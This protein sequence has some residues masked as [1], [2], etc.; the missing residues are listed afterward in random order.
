MRVSTNLS[1]KILWFMLQNSWIS[2]KCSR[3]FNSVCP[4]PFTKHCL[5]VNMYCA[6]RINSN[7][8]EKAI[9]VS[10]INKA[11]TPYLLAV[12]SWSRALFSYSSWA[13]L[14]FLKINFITCFFPL[15]VY[16][17][18]AKLCISFEKLLCLWYFLLKDTTKILKIH[19]SIPIKLGL[20]CS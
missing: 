4:W 10:V 2:I 16:K 11:L 13:P 6:R 8:A 19:I 18:I 20:R 14:F 1:C 9:P 3:L 17:V 7:Q 15:E 5:A 12:L